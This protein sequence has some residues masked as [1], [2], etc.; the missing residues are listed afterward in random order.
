MELLQGQ[1]AGYKV[2]LRAAYSQQFNNCGVYWKN[3]CV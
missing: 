3:F 1:V 2:A